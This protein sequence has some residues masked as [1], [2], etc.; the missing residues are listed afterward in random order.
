M[1]IFEAWR[2]PFSADLQVHSVVNVPDQLLASACVLT[3]E[4]L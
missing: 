3:D 2:K 1:F 4:A